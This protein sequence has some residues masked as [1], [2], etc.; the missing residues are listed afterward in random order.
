MRSILLLLAAVTALTLGPA[1]PAPAAATTPAP[2]AGGP[3]IVHA[4]AVDNYAY[5]WLLDFDMATQS[6]TGTW[7]TTSVGCPVYI[8][9]G[10]F[11]GN[12]FHFHV[13]PS[14][15]TS[16]DD[17]ID[18]TGTVDFPTGT[19]TGTYTGHLSGSFAWE[20]EFHRI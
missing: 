20:W 16:C 1:L 15:S 5:T 11:S 8:V 10:S 19:A 4:M 9:V 2:V 13:V 14:V 17:F 18:F 6:V 12:T 7:D 3:S